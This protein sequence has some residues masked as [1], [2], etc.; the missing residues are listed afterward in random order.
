MIVSEVA[1]GIAANKAPSG[2]T[3]ITS[4]EA[5]AIT[6]EVTDSLKSHR[7]KKKPPDV[8]AVQVVDPKVGLPTADPA[9]KPKSVGQNLN[10]ILNK[11]KK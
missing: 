2:E 11:A 6:A 10:R 5:A 4:V 7:N 9:V 1:A 8:S 3:D